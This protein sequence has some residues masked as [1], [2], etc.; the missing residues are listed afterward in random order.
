[1]AYTEVQY[2][3]ALRVYDKTKSIAATMW[4]LGYPTC[5]QTLYNWISRK[6]LLPEEWSSFRGYNTPEHPRHPPEE[7]KLEALRRCF[8]QGEDVQS[9]SKEIG[10]GRASIYVWRKKYILKGTS[11]MMNSPREHKRG[12]LPEGESAPSAEIKE[13]K[14]RLLDMQME[15]DI[16]KETINVLKKTQAST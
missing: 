14:E 13:L 5:R 6:R 3:E 9:V 15:I 4:I 12:G 11:A 2:R 16:L 10:Y 1:M 7:L 8:E